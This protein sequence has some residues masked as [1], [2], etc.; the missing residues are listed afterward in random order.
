MS[1]HPLETL[2]DAA[3]EAGADHHTRRPSS[4]N[5]CRRSNRSSPSSTRDALRVAEKID[6]DWV[7]HQWIKKAVLLYF[8]THDNQM[9][10]RWRRAR[11]T[12]D[13]V[14]AKFGS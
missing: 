1:A 5:R 9:M 13:K 11:A 14:P 2:I 4:R 10:R 8:R 7:T 3:F 6:G 12:F